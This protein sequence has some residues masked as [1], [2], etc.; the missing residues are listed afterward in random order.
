MEDIAAAQ[1]AAVAAFAVDQAEVV[2]REVDSAQAQA[3]AAEA[4]DSA[5]EVGEAEGA[6]DILEEAI[7]M[8]RLQ[9]SLVSSPCRK[10]EQLYRKKLTSCINLL[11]RWRSMMLTLLRWL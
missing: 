6:G 9:K 4:E 2:H 7:R 11:S 3:A 8:S 10:K 5:L 1:V